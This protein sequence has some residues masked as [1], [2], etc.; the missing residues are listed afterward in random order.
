VTYTGERD[1]T[2]HGKWSSADL[3]Q[4]L[5]DTRYWRGS[6]DLMGTAPENARFVIQAC[7]GFGFCSLVDNLGNYFTPGDDGEKLA[8][9]LTL[10]VGKSPNGAVISSQKVGD[11]VTFSTTLT[12]NPPGDEDPEPIIG[13][14]VYFGLGQESRIGITGEN[15]YVEVTFLLVSAPGDYEVTAWFPGRG[16]LAA[17]TSDPLSFAV[18]QQLTSLELT[19][20]DT[21]VVAGEPLNVTAL[22]TDQS[23]AQL[24]L[25]EQAIFFTLFEVDPTAGEPFTCPADNPL[26]DLDKLT[27]GAAAYKTVITGLEGKA[28][29]GDVDLSGGTYTVCAYFRENPSYAA[30]PASG[31]VVLNQPPQCNIIDDDGNITNLVTVLTSQN[32]FPTLWPTNKRE[33]FIYLSGALDAEDNPDGETPDALNYFFLNIRQDEALDETPD[34]FISESC[35]E[36]WVRSERDGNGDGRVYEIEYLVRDSGDA[37]CTGFVDIATLPHDQGSDTEAVKG[38]LVEGT[39]ASC[40]LDLP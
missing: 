4:D 16:N 36:A 25:A 37:T 33:T 17:S 26:A 23:A 5:D 8:T 14:A 28:T 22:L 39:S 29:V 38:P 35:T 24:P 11:E 19:V 15:G 12:N 1:T 20:P 6:F 40:S 18:N 27:T 3:T 7:N 31:T 30:S 34:A 13:E 9:M 32:D 21:A 10:P 2:L